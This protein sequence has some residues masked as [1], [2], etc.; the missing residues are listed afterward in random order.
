MSARRFVACFVIAASITLPAIADRGSTDPLAAI[1][2]H[3]TAIVADIVNSFRADFE[4]LPAADRLQQSGRLSS[5]LA[6]LRADHLLAASLASTRD[7]LEAILKNAERARDPVGH[8]A[9]KALGGATSD[10]VYT[11]LTPCRLIDTRGFG[12]PIQGGAFAPNAR[13]SYVPNGLCGLPVSGVASIL[14]SF[15]TENL[16]PNSG[17]YLAILAPAAAVTTTVDVFN[18]GAEW[19]ASNT[20]VA[21][22]SAAQFD[23]FVST[24]TAQV[25][26]DVL[27]YFA[28][29]QGGA[30]TSITAGAGLTGGTITSSGTIALASTNL[31]PTAAC[32]TNQI[33]KWNGSAWACAADGNSGGTVTSVATASGLTGGPI[34]SAGTIAL[35]PTNLLPTVACATN[36]IARWNG[37]AWACAADPRSVHSTITSAATVPITTACQNYTGATLLVNAPTSGK[38]V[39]TGSMAVSINHAAGTADYV[40]V[41]I[42]TSATDCGNAW[43]RQLIRVPAAETAFTYQ[44]HTVLA[45]RVFTVTAG[46]ATTYYLNAVSI[47][48]TA[49]AD[50]MNWGALNALF[51]PD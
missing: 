2:L 49:T 27:G 28:P 20:S 44:D 16:T 39:V 35:A 22:G 5:R 50:F 18:L 25:V 3:R 23:I 43:D 19:S 46:S 10:L 13:R 7:S 40:Q 29:P 17:G 33:A 36:Q 15:T 47:S 48:G 42:G 6:A 32:T 4:K 38:V 41:G 37:S 9:T 31:L 12:A 51:I 21:T 24:A 1:D 26:V 34:T 14:I 8:V 45:Q 30:V 11:P